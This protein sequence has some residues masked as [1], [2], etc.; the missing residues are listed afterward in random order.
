MC[1]K[2]MTFEMLSSQTCQIQDFSRYQFRHYNHGLGDIV[3]FVRLIL[4]QSSQVLS[5]VVGYAL[6]DRIH[7][8]EV[9]YAMP[10]CFKSRKVEF[11]KDFEQ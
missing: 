3:K 7:P 6:L 10:V 2:L 11:L 4:P 8:P 9:F 1:K 5:V